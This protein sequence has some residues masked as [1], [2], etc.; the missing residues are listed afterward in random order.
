LT[1]AKSSRWD[2][3][4]LSLVAREALRWAARGETVDPPLT[5]A[6]IPKTNAMDG[7]QPISCAGEEGA[8]KGSGEKERGRSMLRKSQGQGEL[9]GTGFCK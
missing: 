3:D 1:W 7:K 5:I 6:V 8:R 4:R 2:R 9:G